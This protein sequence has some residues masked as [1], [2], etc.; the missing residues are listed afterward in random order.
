MAT[1]TLLYGPNAITREDLVGKTVLDARCAYRQAFNI[2]DSANA[3]VNGVTAANDRVLDAGD[4]LT[5]DKAT[6][7][8]G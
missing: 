3:K 8:K 4:E 7:Q 2:P 5:F 6:G 1:A